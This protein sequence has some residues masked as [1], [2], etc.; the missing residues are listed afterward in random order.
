M[1]VI[2]PWAR[3]NTVVHTQYEFGS[4]L[5]FIEQNFGLGSLHTTDATST[6]I[7]DIFNFSQKPTKFVPEPL[8][9]K[10]TCGGAAS[11]S[12]IIDHDGGVPE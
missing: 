11:N 10:A 4:I 9:H 8:P 5:K 2:S 6:S 1:V 12:E 7:G 3:P